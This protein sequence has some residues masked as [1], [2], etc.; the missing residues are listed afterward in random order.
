MHSNF[1]K[2]GQ[3]CV[4]G[5]RILVHSSIYEVSTRVAEVAGGIR[6]GLPTDAASQMSA[7]SSRRQRVH[8]MAW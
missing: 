6:V 4:A 2:S 7:L 1:V 5:S 8:S 3:G